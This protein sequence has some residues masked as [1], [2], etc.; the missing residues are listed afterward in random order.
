MNTLTENEKTAITQYI[1]D[2]INK[3]DKTLGKIFNDAEAHFYKT[4]NIEMLLWDNA[5]D[6]AELLGIDNF[7]KIN[8]ARYKGL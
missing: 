1:I 4:Q 7:E 6:L 8:S 3:G 5:T 2:G